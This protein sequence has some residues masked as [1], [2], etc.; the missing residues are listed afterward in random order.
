M[1]FRIRSKPLDKEDEGRFEE[2]WG[3]A[4]EASQYLRARNGHHLLTPFECDFCVFLKLKGR[5]PIEHS[6]EDMHLFACIRR[7]N[8]DA[9]WARSSSTAQNNL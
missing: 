8:L 6:Q 1:K 5:F 7:A 2:V 9:F 3:N 4:W